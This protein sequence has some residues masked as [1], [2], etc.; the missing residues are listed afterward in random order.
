MSPFH[1]NKHAFSSG[2]NPGILFYGKR[3]KRFKVRI[4]D[5]YELVQREQERFGSD[6]CALIENELENQIWQGCSS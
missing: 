1:K 6:F 5:K 2:I 3:Q 4:P